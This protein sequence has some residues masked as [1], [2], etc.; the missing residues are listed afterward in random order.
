M[1]RRRSLTTTAESEEV[2]EI[3]SQ[4]ARM[5]SVSC[6][7]QGAEN[8]EYGCHEVQAVDCSIQTE[9]SILLHKDTQTNTKHTIESATHSFPQTMSATPLLFCLPVETNSVPVVMASVDSC[10]SLILKQNDDL[11][12][13][14]TGLSSWEL[15]DHLMSFITAASCGKLCCKGKVQ[16]PDKL[17]LTLMRLRLISNS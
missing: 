2:S 6:T 7:D 16:L 10:T 5:D 15:F 9:D 8:E 13:F 4:E 3:F 11:T 17:L 14:Y 1:D 12:K